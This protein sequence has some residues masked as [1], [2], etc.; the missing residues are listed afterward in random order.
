MIHKRVLVVDDEPL[1]RQMLRD[2]LQMAEYTVVE[3]SDGSEGLRKAETLR[4]D[5][6]LLDLIMPGLDGYA[7]CQ[8]LKG[9]PVT[10]AIPVI[11][12]TASEDFNLNRLAYAAGAV[13]CLTKPFRREA[14]IAIIDAAIGSAERQARAAKDGARPKREMAL[15]PSAAAG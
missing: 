3:A 14:L 4:P 8:E 5:A 6:I 9:N 15:A 12:V 10:R 13:A 1:V 11:F 7:T 2:I